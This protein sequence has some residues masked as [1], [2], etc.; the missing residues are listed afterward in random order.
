MA[1]R[2]GRSKF[3]EISDNQEMATV[4][5]ATQPGRGNLRG[6]ALEVKIAN[7]GFSV[8]VTPSQPTPPSSA[9]QIAM[10]ENIARMQNT[11]STDREVEW[12]Y[13]RLIDLSGTRLDWAPI[14]EVA[15][16]RMKHSDVDFVVS[17]KAQVMRMSYV[18]GA[19]VH[20]TDIPLWRRLVSEDAREAATELAKQYG[21]LAIELE[22]VGRDRGDRPSSDEREAL[23]SVEDVRFAQLRIPTWDCAIETPIAPTIIDRFMR[24]AGI[25]EIPPLQALRREAEE[26]LARALRRWMADAELPEDEQMSIEKILLGSDG[27][28]AAIEALPLDEDDLAAELF[29]MAESERSHALAL[30]VFKAVVMLS[31]WYAEARNQMGIRLSAM[32]KHAAA[33]YELERAASMSPEA[34][35]YSANIGLELLALGRLGEA[36]AMLKHA[37]TL[38]PEAWQPHAIMGYVRL[39]RGDLTRAAASFA[40]ARTRL[41]DDVFGGP[42]ADLARGEAEVAERQGD[43]MAAR[44]T[45]SDLVDRG[46]EIEG[47]LGLARVAIEQG[48]FSDAQGYLES[49]A[50]DVAAAWYLRGLLAQRR[51]SRRAAIRAYRRT[52]KLDPSEWRAG[53]NLSILLIERGH[54]DEAEQILAVVRSHPDSGPLPLVNLAVVA[55]KRDDIRLARSLID[56][57]RRIAPGVPVVLYNAGYLAQRSGQLDEA[58]MLFNQTLANDSTHVPARLALAGIAWARGNW[59]LAEAMIERATRI[60][61]KNREAAKALVWVRRRRGTFG[62]FWRLLGGKWGS[63]ES[64]S[65]A[66]IR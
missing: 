64:G 52:L 37:F 44:A 23:A 35:A 53:L 51:E 59:Y 18:D 11:I 54:L 2:S 47:K 5:L 19:G 22:F 31:P 65:G 17:V 42:L 24:N 60:E 63:S 46:E 1:I 38:D 50:Q 20:I 55:M 66:G 57:A 10:K 29:Q 15:M 45:Y 8:S 4:Q 58:E 41:P 48:T 12:S 32:G 36:E 9:V 49:I 30:D 40:D 13:E 34:V 33:L 27:P 14:C 21:E 61:P 43:W 16:A 56:A 25:L 6:G 26:I 3:T 28:F 7:S 62:V 39:R